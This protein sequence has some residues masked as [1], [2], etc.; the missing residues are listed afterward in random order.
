METFTDYVR[1][2]TEICPKCLWHHS[3]FSPCKN[4]DT[5]QTTRPPTLE[6]LRHDYEKLIENL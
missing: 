1:E 2:R 6:D 5:H 3:R 4:S